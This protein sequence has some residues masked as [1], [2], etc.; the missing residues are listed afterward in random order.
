MQGHGFGYEACGETRVDRI[1]PSRARHQQARLTLRR[2]AAQ[3]RRSRVEG[4]VHFPCGLL[5]GPR[6]RTRSPVSDPGANAARQVLQR[7]G[8]SSTA[9]ACPAPAVRSRDYAS[10]FGCHDC[11]RHDR[12]HRRGRPGCQRF[13]C[14]RFGRGLHLGGNVLPLVAAAA[15]LLLEALPRNALVRTVGVLMGADRKAF[16]RRARI[17][18]TPIFALVARQGGAPRNGMTIPVFPSAATISQR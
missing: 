7:L 17:A 9:A 15:A 16:L 3:F 14:E 11:A 4:Q 6:T 12:G 13:G 1:A 2:C 5:T 10:N 8:L 18:L